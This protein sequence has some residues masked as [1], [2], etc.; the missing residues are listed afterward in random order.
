MK[1][2]DK[3]STTC[4]V[5]LGSSNEG[6]D[7]YPRQHGV[8]EG[9]RFGKCMTNYHCRGTHRRQKSELH[10]FGTPSQFKLKFW[11]SYEGVGHFHFPGTGINLLRAHGIAWDQLNVHICCWTGGFRSQFEYT[12]AYKTSLDICTI[13]SSVWP[14]SH[15]GVKWP[16][17]ENGQ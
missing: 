7:R 11:R 12:S 2:P 3:Q 14:Q 13:Y 15:K 5:S 1:P 6:S 8:G 10:W 4:P 16:G 17:L 9:H